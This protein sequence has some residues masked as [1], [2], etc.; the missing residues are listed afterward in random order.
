MDTAMQDGIH[1][2]TRFIKQTMAAVALVA[3][4]ALTL[5]GPAVAQEATQPAETVKATYGAWDV[6]C[7]TEKPDQCRMR[8][9]GETAD[10][11]KALVVHVGKLKDAKTQDGKIIPAAI[12]ITTPLGSILRAGVKIQI[13]SS[14]PQTGTFEVCLPSGCIVSDAISDEYLGKLMAGTVVKMSFNV[15]QQGT[16]NVDISLKG[17]TKAFNAL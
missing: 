11:K 14:E 12:R 15:L 1:Q 2:L 7:V 10:G 16:V 5:T 9:I 8:Q 17:F 4:V 13:D 6:V 3:L